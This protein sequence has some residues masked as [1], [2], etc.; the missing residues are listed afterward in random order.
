MGEIL[1]YNENMSEKIKIGVSID[2]ECEQPQVLIKTA[3]RTELIENIIKAVEQCARGG[4]P[5][6]T[7]YDGDKIVFLDEADIIRVYVENRMLTVCASQGRYT[8]R[9]TLKEFEESLDD[10]VFVR[11]SRFEVVNLKR[12]VSFDM[13]IAGTIAITFEDGGETWV[14]RR[15]VGN[16]REKLSAISKG[17][18]K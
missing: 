16:I 12:V 11:V 8:S 6:I 2:P 3:E 1:I 5:K 17:G 18:Q 13:S 15:C 9:M 7:V 10:E 14:A 4:A